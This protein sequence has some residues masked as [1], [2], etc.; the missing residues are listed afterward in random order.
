MS[1]SFSYSGV[2]SHDHGDPSN[3]LPDKILQVS[4]FQMLHLGK[5]CTAPHRKYGLL[6]HLGTFVPPKL[7]FSVWYLLGIFP[8]LFCGLRG[9]VTPQMPPKKVFFGTKTLLLALQMYF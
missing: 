1:D 9:G 5:P 6:L 2:T 8:E 3:Q 7:F 4:A